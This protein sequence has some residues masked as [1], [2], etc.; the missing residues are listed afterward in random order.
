MVYKCNNWNEFC[1]SMRK[2]MIPSQT[3]RS[4]D[5]SG[6]HKEKFQNVWN[7]YRT[8]GCENTLC[9]DFITSV[10]MYYYNQS[11]HHPTRISRRDNYLNNLHSKIGQRPLQCSFA[12]NWTRA[13]T[14]ACRKELCRNWKF[15]SNEDIKTDKNNKKVIGLSSRGGEIK[16]NRKLKETKQLSQIKL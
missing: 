14:I 9:Y 1:E 2:V 16:T 12:V 10:E 7:T 5:S 4:I 11:E 13:D 6:K 3:K 15:N 8:V